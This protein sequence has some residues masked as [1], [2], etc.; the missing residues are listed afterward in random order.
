[1]FNGHVD[2]PDIVCQTAIRDA[3]DFLSAQEEGRSVGVTRGVQMA[4]CTRWVR[5]RFGCFKLNFDG[6]IDDRGGRCG[7]G[8]VIRDWNGKF[9]A[10][11]AVGR[12]YVTDPL[13]VEAMAAREGLQFARELGLESIIVEGDSQQLVGL[14]WFRG[15]RKTMV[16]WGCSCKA[17]IVH[18]LAGFSCA[19]V[20][21]VRRSGNEVAHSVAQRAVRSLFFSTWEFRS[22]VWLL[23]SLQGDAYAQFDVFFSLLLFYL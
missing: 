17:D 7:M 9:I 20:C 23:F 21:F 3:V 13:V 12:L 19:E 2:R 15:E 16:R 6:G 22:P 4:G 5:P 14:I 1:M 8:A 18:L 11:R 10:A